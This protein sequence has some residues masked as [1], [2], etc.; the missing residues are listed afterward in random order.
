MGGR[1]TG[2][3]FLRLDA[4]RGDRAWLVVIATCLSLLTSL[5]V[6]P[7]YAANGDQTTYGAATKKC[8]ISD[9][10]LS[11]VSGYVEGNNGI[12]A[13]NS[14]SPA[15]VYSLDNSCN[16]TS[17]VTLKE[18]VSDIDDIIA[19]SDGR[20]WIADV[21]G[22]KP[23]A[24]VSVLRWGGYS[25]DSRRFDLAYP[26]G[27]RDAEAILVSLTGVIAV[28]TQAANGRSGI[29][30]AQLPFADKATLTKVGEI[31]MA[32]L[33]AENDRSPA[34]LLITGGAVSP[35]GNHVALRTP[36]T[37]YEW[38]TPDG[39]IVSAL[40]TTKP[41]V[42][43]L[44]TQTTGRA[45]SYS[46]DDTKLLTVSSG[47]PATVESIPISRASGSDATSASIQLS[48]RVVVGVAGVGALIIVL[49]LV[50]WRLRRRATV[51][52]TYQVGEEEDPR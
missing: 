18:P 33:R 3:G 39:D 47:L 36:T 38:Y 35:N 34:S 28:I 23:R 46:D 20:L 48:P 44:T 32:S 31:D 29:Y 19:A 50:A 21:G 43:G 8:E 5:V 42:I 14:G 16:V 51:V 9:S 22:N 1:R 15:T 4:S 52:T 24:D 45:I 26:D 41:N 27:P 49:A 6:D 37:A 7:A 10:R 17:V 40:L 12:F 2:S 25:Q 11:R 30:T 13:I